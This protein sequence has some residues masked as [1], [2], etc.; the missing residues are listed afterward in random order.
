M[1]I[2][3]DFVT[4]SSSTSF[5]IINDGEFNLKK[6]VEAIGISEDSKFIDI[7]RGLFESFRD[8]M[9]PARD[10]YRKYENKYPSFE[11]F[12]T[13]RFS[14]DTLERILAAESL[15]KDIYIGGLSSDNNEIE[16]FFCTDSF[17]I[18]SGKLFIDATENAW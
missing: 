5:V 4:N 1:K 6:F 2:K 11:E 7:F 16:S 15:K 9:E 8:N 12:V 18:E 10:Y 13:S 3:Y 14:R 17:L